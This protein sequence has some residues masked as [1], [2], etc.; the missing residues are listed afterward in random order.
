MAAWIALASVCIATAFAES[1]TVSK[2]GALTVIVTI[3]VSG[4]PHAFKGVKTIPELL[5]HIGNLSPAEKKRILEAVDSGFVT[6]VRL[7][8]NSS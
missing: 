4:A 7:E 2:T 3:P 8:S 6:A 1:E 5:S